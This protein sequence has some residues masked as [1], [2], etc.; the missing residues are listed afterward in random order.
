M[1]AGVVPR[2]AAWQPGDQGALLEREVLQLLS[3]VIVGRR[4]DAV[5]AGPHVV[6]VRVECQDLVFRVPFFNLPGDQDVLDLAVPGL[7]V[8]AGEHAGQLQRYGAGPLADG[9]APVQRVLH[10]GPEDGI[11]VQ[12]GV[13][14]ELRVFDRD[15]GELEVGGDLLEGGDDASF[16]GEFA[17]DLVVVG[18]DARDDV[19]PVILQAL[20]GGQVVLVAHEAPKPQPGRDEEESQ[21][22]EKSPEPDP[23]PAGRPYVVCFFAG[24]RH[25]ESIIAYSTALPSRVLL[26]PPAGKGWH[27]RPPARERSRGRRRR[28]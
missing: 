5:D 22:E 20:D 1:R 10:D 28:R 11:V 26:S 25:R 24:G 27:R 21:E 4:G 6:Q 2:R 12:P 3:E 18:I 9:K 17:D 15:E 8:P 16:D 13:V 14:I 19:G 7:F 23:A